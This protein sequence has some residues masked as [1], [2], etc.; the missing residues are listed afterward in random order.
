MMYGCKVN[1]QHVS[2]EG[3]KGLEHDAHS[4]ISFTKQ[5]ESIGVGW[6]KG[7]LDVVLFRNELTFQ[8]TR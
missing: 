6:E 5:I 3:E 7:G 1:Y 2:L 4:H 8:L